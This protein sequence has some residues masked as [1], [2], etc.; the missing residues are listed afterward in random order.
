MGRSPSTNRSCYPGHLVTDKVYVLRPVVWDS[1]HD[2]RVLNSS[3]DPSSDGK[4]WGASEASSVGAE[5]VLVQCN[6]QAGSAGESLRWLQGCL[7]S[8]GL[9]LSTYRCSTHGTTGKEY[10]S[11]PT[12]GQ[13]SHTQRRHIRPCA[14]VSCSRNHCRQ[15]RFSVCNTLR[16]TDSR[17]LHRV[18]ATRHVGVP[19]TVPR[20]GTLSTSF[21]KHQRYGILKIPL[22]DQ[23]APH[24]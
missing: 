16:L 22:D 18:S 8:N 23:L 6:V 4:S 5:G 12:S 11:L 14:R 9:N 17:A 20:Y 2:H 15:D 10:S 1:S 3:H 13:S 19:V 21:E 24:F 7:R